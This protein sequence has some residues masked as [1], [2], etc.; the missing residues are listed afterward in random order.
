MEGLTDYITESDWEDILTVN[1]VLIDDAWPTLPAEVLPLRRRGPD[2]VMSDSEVVTVALFIDTVF[3]GDED[4]GLAFLRQY[5]LALFPT[6]L[7]ASRFNRRRRTLMLAMETLRCHFRDAW[8][9]A[10]PLKPDTDHLRVADSAPI[11]ICTYTRGSRCQSIPIEYRDEWFGVCTSKK[12]KF[13]GLRCHA[14]IDLGQMIDSWCLAP[15]SY[16]DLRPIPTLLEGQ[17]NLAVIGNCFRLTKTLCP[18]RVRGALASGSGES[19]PFPHGCP[20]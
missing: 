4:K 17:Q 15:G 19:S 5:H 3:G 1:L 2:P 13:F 9:E 14:M 20:A 12:T 11:P 7:E 8:R 16:H 6:L 10:H 18:R